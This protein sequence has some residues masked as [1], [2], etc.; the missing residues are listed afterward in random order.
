MR[1]HLNDRLVDIVFSGRMSDDERGHL[2]ACAFCAGEL[3][4]VEATLSG[5]ALGL[6]S[7][8]PTSGLR[9]RV[10][11]IQ[12]WERQL[13]ALARFVDLSV[14]AAREILA[15]ARKAG[16][17]E[18]GPIPNMRLF[19]FT[20]G[21]LTAGADVGLVGIPAG[22]AFPWHAHV[23]KESVLILSGGYTDNSGQHFGPGDFDERA[24]GQAHSYVCDTGEEMVLALVLRGSV[25]FG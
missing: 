6:A 18:G 15:R 16:E 12:D 13:A 11:A 21:S 1:Q 5:V 14:E 24:D 3:A 2:D 20:G 25:E 17:W 9:G 22:A 10:L 8:M 4:E 7:V 23:G 19:H